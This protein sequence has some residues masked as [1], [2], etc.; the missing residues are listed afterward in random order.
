MAAPL[1][2]LKALQNRPKTTVVSQT[3]QLLLATGLG[4]GLFLGVRALA[5][6]FKKG[7]REQQALH[8]GN[9]AAFATQL[10]LAFENDNALGWGTDEVLI[11]RVVESIPDYATFKKVQNA[12]R[13]LYGSTLAVDLKSELNTEE[14]NA[15][16]ELIN[17][18]I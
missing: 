12:Y 16:L 18:K 7:V 13:D 15:L 3:T 8:P 9:P 6:N 1:L 5:K 10:K 17:T 2:A 11:Y 14:Y 4:V